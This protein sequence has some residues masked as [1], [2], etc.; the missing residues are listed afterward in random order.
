MSALVEVELPGLT[1]AVAEAI[2]SAAAA[3]G[4]PVRA[5]PGDHSRLLHRHGRPGVEIVDRAGD[6]SIASE[7]L[8][9]ADGW[10]RDAAITALLH[11][12]LA[13][14]GE[15]APD[16]RFSF[17]A[18]WGDRRHPGH[19]ELGLAELLGLVD[20]GGLLADV[21]YDVVGP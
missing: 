3:R 14:I 18:G 4:A 7:T 15:V 11:E 21:C 17:Q 9:H 12:A 5:W 13:F 16:G 20:A 10:P 1:D 19:V 2:A 8:E 6:P